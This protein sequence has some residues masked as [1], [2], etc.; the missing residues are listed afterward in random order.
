MEHA[1]DKPGSHVL[2]VV[3][4]T[5]PERD[6]LLLDNR[7]DFAVEVLPPL[8]VLLVDGDDHTKPKSR[9]TDYLRD[10]LAPAIDP[11]P[12]M[13]VR[14][15]PVQEF[16]P[17]LLDPEPGKE[18]SS[19]PRVLVLANV[20]RLTTEQQE[21]VA[22]FLVRGGGV[23]VTL[24]ER[25]DEQAYNKQLHRNG[26][27][28]LPV[29]LDQYTTAET[30]HTASPQPATFVHPALERF[31]AEPSSGLANARFRHWWKFQPAAISPSTVT[32]ARLDNKD[33]LLVEGRYRG[34][35]VLVST[36][37]FDK[38]WVTN[39]PD[40]PEFPVLAHELVNALA[41]VRARRSTTCHKVSRS[42]IGWTPGRRPAA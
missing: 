13:A 26:Q 24:G 36:V 16:K 38:S 23:L 32:V 6:Q 9:G 1:F 37:P 35:R 10:A 17:A 12:T 28:W 22:Q 34:G 14:V 15:V 27:G 39:L 29:A 41:G 11:A 30:D 19:R 2:S 31:R 21:A 4:E 8:P 33:A 3:V 20:A 7:Q 42:A 40:L 5:Q 25:V 18:I